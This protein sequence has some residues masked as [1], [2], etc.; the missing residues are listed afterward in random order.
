M[1]KKVAPTVVV[2]HSGGGTADLSVLPV[3]Y[4]YIFSSD[5]I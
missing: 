3:S 5:K 1:E 2:A 4:E